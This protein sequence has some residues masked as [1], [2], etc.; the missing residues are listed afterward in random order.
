MEL[1]T[2]IRRI[3]VNSSFYLW[4]FYDKI[5]IQNLTSFKFLRLFIEEEVVMFQES[6]EA[7]LRVMLFHQ[8]NNN[9]H[10]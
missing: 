8:V 7:D 4:F 1:L 6:G 5:Y 9:L 3:I 10:D 2:N